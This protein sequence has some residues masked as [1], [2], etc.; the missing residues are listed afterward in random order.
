MGWYL[1]LLVFHIMICIEH[2]HKVRK[3]KSMPPKTSRR[4]LYSTCSEA[5]VDRL[6]GIIK[7]QVDTGI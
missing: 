2:Y 5:K 1:W 7:R 3:G 6:L 4:M